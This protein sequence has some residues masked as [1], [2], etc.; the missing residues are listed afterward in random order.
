MSNNIK[1]EIDRIEIPHDIHYRVVL[2]VQKVQSEMKHSRSTR[3]RAI[4]ITASLLLLL[5]GYGSYTY[6]RDHQEPAP[7]GS[8][9]VAEDGAVQVPAIQLPNDS[10]NADMIG[11]IVYNGKIYTQTDTAIAAAHAQA[12][13]GE[14]LGTTKG[15]I[16]E[17]SKQKEYA[18]EFAST[19]G[20]MDVYAVKGYDKDFRIMSYSEH[21]GTVYA[22]FYECLNGITVHDGEDVFGKLNMSGN[23]VSAQYQSFSDWDNST[24]H[25]YTIADIELLNTFTLELNRLTPYPRQDVENVL[26]NFRN[27]DD[28]RRLSISLN[29]GSIVGLIVLK[30]GYI[31]Y[32]SPS[33]Y[34][35]MDNEVFAKLWEA[36]EPNDTME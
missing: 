25:F 21:D 8:L 10:E 11:L 19:I 33:V 30:E 5:G 35:K 6:I 14:K 12:L 22:E 1:Q 9:V 2:G 4:A 32:G 18:I 36:L 26:G 27:D 31:Y 29:D 16:D 20:K 28:Y 23:I 34:F 13:L 24:D 15:N 7:P 17:W 3:W